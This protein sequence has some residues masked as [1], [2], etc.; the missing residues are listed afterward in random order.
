MS[1]DEIAPLRLISKLRNNRMIRA[2]EALGM[3]GPQIAEAIGVSYSVWILLESLKESPLRAD[4]QWRS[5]VIR[6]ADWLKMMP[7]DLWPEEALAVEQSTLEIEVSAAEARTLM[8]MTHQA[9]LPDYHGELEAERL[10]GALK[11]LTPRQEGVLRARF[12]FD[13]KEAMTLED[14]GKLFG[15][16]PER[17][18]QIEAKAL[19]LLRHP[20][21]AKPILLADDA[22]VTDHPVSG[23]SDPAILRCRSC[24]SPLSRKTP[25]EPFKCGCGKTVVP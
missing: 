2:R 1:A 4:G 6:I 5:V 12:G 3:S 25:D 8:E 22:G 9:A 23:G 7:E 13:G 24:R 15:V 20:S 16:S 14:T 19:R 21:R 18:R 17:L 10:E 11:T